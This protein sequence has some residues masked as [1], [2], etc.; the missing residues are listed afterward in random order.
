MNETKHNQNCC[1]V[2][3]ICIFIPTLFDNWILN[4]CTFS[5][6]TDVTEV[7]FMQVFETSKVCRD[8]NIFEPQKFLKLQKSVIPQRFWN[9]PKKSSMNHNFWRF[10][11]FFSSFLKPQTSLMLKMVLN[12]LKSLKIYKFLELLKAIKASKSKKKKI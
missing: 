7:I 5:Q 11:I 8:S 12:P 2:K 9:P 6:S 1:L 4:F 10:V 3:F